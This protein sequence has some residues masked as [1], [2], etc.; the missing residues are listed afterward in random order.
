MKTKPCAIKTGNVPF[1]EQGSG[2]CRTMT[3]IDDSQIVVTD[4]SVGETRELY[5]RRRPT[6]TSLYQLMR[7]DRFWRELEILSRVLTPRSHFRCHDWRLG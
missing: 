1:N 4:I 6:G 2:S 3:V 5:T 7:E